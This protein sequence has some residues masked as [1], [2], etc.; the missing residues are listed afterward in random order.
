[1]ID[2]NPASNLY[3][4]GRCLW[5]DVVVHDGERSPLVPSCHHWCVVAV[6]EDDGAHWD[7]VARILARRIKRCA[8]RQRARARRAANAQPRRLAS[9]GQWGGVR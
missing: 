4:L 3:A 6:H 5:C 1:M 9:R 7:I 8:A 2:R